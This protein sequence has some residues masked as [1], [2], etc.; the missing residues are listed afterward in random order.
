MRAYYA[1]YKH[2]RVF[3][4]GVPEGWMVSVYDI[5]KC[6]WLDRCDSVADTLKEAKINA[7]ARASELN[8]KKAL[9]LRWH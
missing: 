4:F 3:V 6:Q 2:V 1:T 8:G 7:Q 5:Q 9:E